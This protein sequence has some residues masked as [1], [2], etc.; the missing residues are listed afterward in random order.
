MIFEIS[1]YD[2]EL[3]KPMREEAKAI[4]M[5]EIMTPEDLNKELQKKGFTLILVN[6]V[7]GC[8][9]G[10]ARPGLRLAVEKAREDGILPDNMLT[11]FAGMEK[12]A[13][14][15]VRKYFTGYAPSSPQIALLKNG[16]LISLIERKDIENS[17]EIRVAEKVYNL[18]K[19]HVKRR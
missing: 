5:K 9:A 6:S 13:T 18:L 12:S 4:G 16:L 10:K 3:V 8:A 11:V 17:D 7:C 15:E 1:T 2:P 14:A 19:E